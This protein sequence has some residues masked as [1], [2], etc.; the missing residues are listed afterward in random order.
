M[1]KQLIVNADDYGR[2][3]GVSR[4][5]RNAYL[6]GIVTSTSVMIN[7]PGVAADMLM[8]KQDCPGL[9]IGLHLTLTSG[10]PRLSTEKIPS[11]VR[12][13]GRFWNL[14]EFLARRETLHL[15]QIRAEWQAQLARFYQ[16]AGHMPDHLDAHHHI[17]YRSLALFELLC[18][19]ASEMGIPIRYLGEEELTGLLSWMAQEEQHIVDFPVDEYAGLAGTLRSPQ[20]LITTFYDE[21]ATEAI[22]LEI[23]STLPADGVTELMCHPGYADMLLLD[24]A[25][26]SIYNRQRER[27][28]DILCRKSIKEKII[29]EGIQLISFSEL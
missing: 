25:A 16:L 8:A 17:A 1:T 29:Q 6:Q 20:A 22:L 12:P 11:L 10:V 2:T 18:S 13:D 4:G 9:G 26:G 3:P 15:E 24:A 5:I 28:L 19:I 14:E 23:L 7:F 21:E 27:E